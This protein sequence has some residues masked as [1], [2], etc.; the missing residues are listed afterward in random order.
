MFAEMGVHTEY[1]TEPDQLKPALERAFSSG[2]TMLINVV[3]DNEIIPPQLIGRIK[4]YKA[5]F[6]K[7]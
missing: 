1:V 6:A 2:K 3:P 7:K 4:Y 5:Q